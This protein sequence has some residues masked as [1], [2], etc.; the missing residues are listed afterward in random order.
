M[1]DK[2]PNPTTGVRVRIQLLFLNK[3][4]HALVKFID[5]CLKELG[6]EFEQFLSEARGTYLLTGRLLLTR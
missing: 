6:H 4:L 5:F 2:E 1:L 3:L